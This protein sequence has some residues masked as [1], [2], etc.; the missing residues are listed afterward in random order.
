MAT[1]IGEPTLGCH[2]RVVD[3]ELPG[4]RARTSRAPSRS[5]AIPGATLFHGYLDDPATTEA[6]IVERGDDGF[7]WFDTGDRAPW[8]TLGYH[9]FA[10]RAATC[11]RS[12]ARTCRVVEVE[13]VLAEHPAV[14]DVAVIGAPDAFLDEVPHAFV[15]ARPRLAR[16]RR[17]LERWCEDRLAP[18]KRPR[19]FHLVDELPRTSVGKIRKFLLRTTTR[20]LRQRP[21]QKEV[22]HE[23]GD[24]HVGGWHAGAGLVIDGRSTASAPARRV[25]D[26]LGDD[27]EAM[28]A[29]AERAARPHDVR[30]PRRRRP[31]SAGPPAVAPRLPHLPRPPAQRPQGARRRDRQGLGRDPGLLLLQ[32]RRR[33]RPPRPGADLTRV[34]TVRLRAGGRRHHRQGGL[35]PPPGPGCRSHR[36][37]HDLL[38]LE[39]PRPPDARDA[40]DARTRRRARTAPTP[41]DRC[42]SPRTSWSRSA[43]AAPTTSR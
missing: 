30:R 36:R 16:P 6:A 27:G 22:K 17:R 7:V 33:R 32:R 1:A 3:A 4:R 2:V 41:W 35:R 26:L 10:G 13:Q 31:R 21:Q 20:P 38:R 18:S 42:S 23:M 12:P 8:T 39:R 28:D 24:V 19:A 40:A 37:L 9:Y 43:A 5:A 11:S 34:R 14:A 25:I 15:V 29:A